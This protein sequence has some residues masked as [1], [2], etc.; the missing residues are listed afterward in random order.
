MFWGNDSKM[1]LT[2]QKTEDTKDKC[3]SNSGD[4][5]ASRYEKRIGIED[6]DL[7]K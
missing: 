6:K 1:I 7:K 4:V 3:D 5:P 2:H